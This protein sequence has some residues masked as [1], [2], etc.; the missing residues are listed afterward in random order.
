[1]IRYI[2]G[3]QAGN[4]PLLST[5]HD[6][7]A[8]E[9]AGQ[10]TIS[11]SC[12]KVPGTMLLLELLEARSAS[13]TQATMSPMGPCDCY[14]ICCEGVQLPVQ[15]RQTG[16]MQLMMHVFCLTESHMAWYQMA[17]LFCRTLA[18]PPCQVMLQHATS[19]ITA[20]THRVTLHLVLRS[21]GAVSQ[22]GSLLDLGSVCLGVKAVQGMP[23]QEGL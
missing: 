1:M 6:K 10:R 7:H 2:C 14:L 15:W 13:C 16:T 18:A 19:N 9:D 22:Q 4:A 5:R 11:R 23:P 17:G 3:F 12:D 20:T 21:R 8:R